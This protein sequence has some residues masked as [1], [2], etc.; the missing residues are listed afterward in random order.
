[1]TGV[2][3]RDAGFLGALRD[4]A[5]ARPRDRHAK[6]VEPRSDISN[7]AWGERGRAFESHASG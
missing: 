3:H 5:I 7:A 2:G 1:V 6:H 4:H